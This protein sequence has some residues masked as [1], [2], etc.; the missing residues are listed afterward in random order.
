MENIDNLTID[1][2]LKNAH[3]NRNDFGGNTVKEIYIRNDKY[4][5]YK[6][7]ASKKIDELRFAQ[8]NSCNDNEK[9]NLYPYFYRIKMI[10]SEVCMYPSYTTY[11]L[12]AI[13]ILGKAFLKTE[14]NELDKQIDKLSVNVN[15][16]LWRQQTSVKYY[17]L[18]GLCFVIFMIIL[19]VVSYIE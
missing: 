14:H 16:E 8:V 10:L 18:A 13:S 5:L 15:T 3:V 4:I 6:V 7:N 12:E 17:M 2:F 19:F 1:H 9:E 11:K